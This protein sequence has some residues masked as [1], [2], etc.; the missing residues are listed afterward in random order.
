ML[1]G[2]LRSFDIKNI[3]K[4]LIVQ[5]NIFIDLQITIIHRFTEIKKKIQFIKIGQF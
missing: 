2:N 5:C 1:S 3:K 4:V